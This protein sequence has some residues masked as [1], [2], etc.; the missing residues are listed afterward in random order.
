[1]RRLRHAIVSRPRAILCGALVLFAASQIA[2]GLFLTRVCPEVR[3]PEYGSL[4]NALEARIAEAPGS[5]L[6]LVLG[7]SRSANIFRASP[8]GPG[9]AGPDPLVFNFAT[10]FTGPVREL[11]MLR[12][13]LG[14][15][16]RP[17]WV[18]AEVWTPFLTERMGF[19]EETHILKSDLL[20]ADGP[21]LA[22][23]LADPQPAHDK[24]VEG[25]LWPAF[26]H[27]S[28][29]LAA[30]SPFL[31]R[32]VPRLPGDWSDPSLRAVEGFGWLPVPDPRPTDEE[33]RAHLARYTAS[34]REVLTDFRISPVADRA[35]HELLRTCADQGIRTAL[36]LLPE[37]SSVR[38]CVFPEVEAQVRAFLADLAREHLTPVI[39]TRDWVRDDDFIDSRHT[40]PHVAAPYTERFGREV[41]RP[42]MEGRS[43][44]RHLLLGETPSPALPAPAH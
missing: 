3:D 21:L 20:P 8:P 5:P 37:H 35:L 23:Y 39:D 7:S 11:Q 40:L 9:T 15:G 43:L 34:I 6:V 26:S 24:L 44:S 10:L 38:A 25:V 17:C 30:Y 29:L 42:L 1:M 4:C 14:R 28:Q 36:V 13:L 12:R 16:V 41:L 2:L 22:R 18:V 31:D 19:D 33:L 27:R 32:P